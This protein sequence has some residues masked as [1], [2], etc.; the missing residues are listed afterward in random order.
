MFIYILNKVYNDWCHHHYCHQYHHHHYHLWCNHPSLV[1]MVF[2]FIYRLNKVYNDWCHHHYCHQYHHHHHYHLWCNHSLV[3]MAFMFIY[4]LNEVY[5]W[6]N[7]NSCVHNIIV[8]Q[9]W[10]EQVKGDQQIPH[11]LFKRQFR[12]QIVNGLLAVRGHMT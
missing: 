7:V 1:K 3:K 2:M 4:R 12:V 11:L 9:L 8:G 6:N 10:I 5:T